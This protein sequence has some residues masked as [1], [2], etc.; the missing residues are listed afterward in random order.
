MRLWLQKTARSGWL[1]FGRVY[2]LRVA[3]SCTEAEY[4]LIDRHQLYGDDLWLSSSALDYLNTAQQAFDRARNCS[5]LSL[6]GWQSR[7]SHNSNGI[8]M[9]RAS[10]RE[11][12]VSVGDLVAGAVLEA[13]SINEL[14]EAERGIRAG[15]QVLA[16][17]LSELE[18]FELG[19]EKLIEA[20]DPRGDGGA[21]PGTWI[22]MGGRR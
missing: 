18:N 20:D 7:W 13:E 12:Q 14:M 8:A 21:P 5:V 11:A 15:F 6:Q 2:V 22:Q 17:R 4:A 1:G 16:L 19:E 9:A 3:L 10:D